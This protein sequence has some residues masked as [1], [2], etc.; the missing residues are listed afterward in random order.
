[1]KTKQTLKSPLRY[2]GGKSRAVN[3]LLRFLPQGLKQVCS[4]F[5]GG[6]S[7]ELALASQGVRVR[8]YDAFPPLVDF[9]QVLLKQPDRLADEVEQYLP[10]ARD[11]FYELQKKCLGIKSKLKRAAVFYTLNRASFSGAT[12]SGGMSPGHGRFTES[13]IAYLRNFR[14]EGLSVEQ[15]DFRESLSRHQEDFL[16]LDPP[17]AIGCNLY[18]DKGSTHRDFDHL[19]LAEVLKQRGKWVLSYN[20]SPQIRACYAGYRIVTPEWKYGM[21]KDKASRE[22]VILSEDVK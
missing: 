2:P 8:A 14:V 21:S 3:G 10:L 6:G 20:D 13:S 7:L 22:V 15:A 12:L 11:R 17:Y 16:Y 19:G 5:M 18:G 4:P 9:W 1:M